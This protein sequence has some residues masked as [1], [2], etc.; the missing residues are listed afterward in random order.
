M[1]KTMMNFRITNTIIELYESGI[2]SY[3]K[4][5]KVHKERELASVSALGISQ[6]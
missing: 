4:N 1:Y 5:N 6:H 3:I 2:K